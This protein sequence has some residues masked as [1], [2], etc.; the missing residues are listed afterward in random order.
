MS[1]PRVLLRKRERDRGTF[2]RQSDQREVAWSRP[3][4]KFREALGRNWVKSEIREALAV[5]NCRGQA[6]DLMM[7]LG[8]CWDVR[9]ASGAQKALLC[10]RGR[11]GLE[12]GARR[13]QHMWSS[14]PLSVCLSWVPGTS[15]AGVGSGA[16][17]GD[18]RGALVSSRGG[19]GT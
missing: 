16:G 14:V 4:C 9:G 8:G 11:A 1:E 2:R 12:Q 6:F 7:I 10:G 3:S 15:A 19:G 17:P 13:G 5:G 18:A